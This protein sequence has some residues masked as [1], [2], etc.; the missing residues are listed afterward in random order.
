MEDHVPPRRPAPTAM[1]V[2]MEM[3]HT[4]ESVP[5]LIAAN[6]DVAHP[7]QITYASFAMERWWRRTTTGPTPRSLAEK[8]NVNRLVPGDRTVPG[9][10][11]GHVGMAWPLSASVLQASL[12]TT[13]NKLLLRHQ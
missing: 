11:Q 10:S 5:Q 12:G 3:G 4:A 13:V 2:S 9:V 8:Q 6:I 7:R 1:R